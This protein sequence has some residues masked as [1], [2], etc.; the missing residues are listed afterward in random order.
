[1]ELASGAIR[2]QTS[3]EHGHGVFA[4]RAIVR[5][6]CLASLTLDE[7]VHV[8]R[9]DQ[10]DERLAKAVADYGQFAEWVA[11][12]ESTYGSLVNAIRKCSFALSDA[13]GERRCAFLGKWS[14]MNHSCLPSIG[15]VQSK[16]GVVQIFALRAIAQ[17]EQ[18]MISYVDELKSKAERQ[19]S[20]AS[21]YE[22]ECQCVRCSRGNVS[23]LDSAAANNVARL[24]TWIL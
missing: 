7:I 11:H 9:G 8:S 6:E 18:L 14:Y 5:R 20:L 1:M 2:V 10:E 13:S 24:H 3:R 22:F 21:R 23:T 12:A 4:A 16:E 15:L 17:D 19:A